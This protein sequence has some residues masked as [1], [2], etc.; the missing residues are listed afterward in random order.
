MA[1]T[2]I[3]FVRKSLCFGEQIVPLGL[4]VLGFCFLESGTVQLGSECL[5]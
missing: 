4:S 2:H 1:K 3:P 5:D